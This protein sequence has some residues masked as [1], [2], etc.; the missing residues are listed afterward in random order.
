MTHGCEGGASR[1]PQIEASSH[2]GLA[3]RPIASEALRREPGIA[4]RR[5]NSKQATARQQRGPR[6]RRR[7]T[8]S[9][10]PPHQNNRIVRRIASSPQPDWYCAGTCASAASFFTASVTRRAR[11]A[12]RQVHAHS[13][14][15][16]ACG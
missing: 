1:H 10:T 13:L 2:L 9:V 12:E 7:A 16:G 5:H 14:G 4:Q 11:A 8:N 15:R 3:F 6:A